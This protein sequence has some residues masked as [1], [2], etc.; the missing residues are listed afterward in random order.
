MIVILFRV[1]KLRK[2]FAVVPDLSYVEPVRSIGN[3]VKSGTVTGFK[4]RIL[5]GRRKGDTSAASD[6]GNPRNHEAYQRKR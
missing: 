1:S 6:N 3:I 2:L 5:A 4:T